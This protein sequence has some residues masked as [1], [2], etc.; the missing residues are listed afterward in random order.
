MY[1][2]LAYKELRE[3][4]LIG[5]L[6]CGA[7]LL[8]VLDQM[9]VTISRMLG[10]DAVNPNNPFMGRKIPFVHEGLQDW[11]ALIAGIGAL[12]LGFRQVLGESARGT[13]LFLLHRPAPWDALILTKIV[14]GALLLLAATLAPLLILAIWASIPGT[15]ASPFDWRMTEH[16][17]RLAF[18]ATV[19]FLAAWLT[20]LRLAPWHRSRLLPL[21]PA[22]LLFYY[23]YA[24]AL[25]PLAGWVAVGVADLIYLSAIRLV[26]PDRE[27]P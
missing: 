20:G 22:G 15:H 12:A 1:K 5:G 4:A 13:W 14:A 3:N 2:A 24:T 10:L 23:V 19:V 27:Y 9:G 18:S 6:I 11:L 17:L 25:W 21:I 8:V 26:A 7:L 16:P